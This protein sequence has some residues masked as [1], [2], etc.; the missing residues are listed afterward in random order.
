MHIWH[1]WHGYMI[2]IITIVCLLILMTCVEWKS[3][4]KHWD[5]VSESENKIFVKEIFVRHSP[6][7]GTW[8]S[9]ISFGRQK[10]DQK[11]AAE[12]TRNEIVRIPNSLA[13]S[14]AKDIIPSAI[15]QVTGRS[16]LLLRSASNCRKSG[17]VTDMMEDINSG[18]RWI[19]LRGLSVGRPSEMDSKWRVGKWVE[20]ACRSVRR[21]WL[22]SVFRKVTWR[23]AWHR[24]AAKLSRGLMW[25]CAGNGKIRTWGWWSILIKQK[26]STT[27]AVFPSWARVACNV[28]FYLYARS[29]RRTCECPC[30]ETPILLAGIIH[31]LN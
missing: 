2:F 21:R 5:H 9:S 17:L 11:Q 3:C 14:I 10:K 16:D 6:R 29:P 31:K 4:T 28:H 26:M 27:S 24:R 1:H 8:P 15:T 22:C 23:P 25:P 20:S 30:S 18:M 19:G 12:K 13:K 7:T